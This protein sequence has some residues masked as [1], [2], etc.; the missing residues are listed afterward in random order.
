MEQIIPSELFVG[1]PELKNIRQVKG[2]VRVRQTSP[3]ADQAE[4]HEA[5]E[6]VGGPSSDNGSQQQTAMKAE[7]RTYCRR[8]YHWPVLEELRS[9][10]ERRHHDEDGWDSLIKHIDEEV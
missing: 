9:N 3:V 4:P 5:V 10:V 2:P 8:I 6:K 1:P 7:R